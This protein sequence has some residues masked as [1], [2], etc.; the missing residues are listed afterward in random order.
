LLP[1]ISSQNTHPKVAS[2]LLER[3]KAEAA[4]AVLRAS[5]CDGQAA[6]PVPLADALTA[7]RVRL[8]CDLLTEGYLYQRAH[9]DG[10]KR[11]GRDWASEMEVLVGEVCRLCM[12]MG[13]LDKMLVLPWRKE[14]EK[15]L[16]KCL[17]DHAG[18]DPSSKAGS[19][20]VVFY[21]QVLPD[22]L[23]FVHD[24]IKPS[25]SVV[26]CQ[27]SGIKMC[28]FYLRFGLLGSIGRPSMVQ[29][30]RSCLYLFQSE[31][32]GKLEL[33]TVVDLLP[34]ACCVCQLESLV[35]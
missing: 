18:Q 35:R 13:I 28:M 9:C 29:L 30:I 6:G 15:Y 11:E 8:Q 3:Q 10:V 12:R 23:L 24:K 4:L 5:G 21:I 33:W 16:K 1:E 34:K 26:K 22:V 27:T 19:L 2:V 20:L 32:H 7:V 25:C 31:L 14:E 17:L